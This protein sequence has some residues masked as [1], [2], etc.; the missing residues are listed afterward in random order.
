MSQPDKSLLFDQEL[1]KRREFCQS[2]ELKR[3]DWPTRG[4]NSRV[5]RLGKAV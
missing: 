4:V 3:S 5:M 2:R 1:A